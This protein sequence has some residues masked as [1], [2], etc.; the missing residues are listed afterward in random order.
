MQRQANQQNADSLRGN[1]RQNAGSLRRNY[2]RRDGEGFE[3]ME[4]HALPPPAAQ[5][6]PPGPRPEQRRTL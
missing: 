4:L 6:S 5:Q 3:S 1:Y 2:Q